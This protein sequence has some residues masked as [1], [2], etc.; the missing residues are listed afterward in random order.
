V[1]DD[2]EDEECDG[3]DASREFPLSLFDDELEDLED[4]LESPSDGGSSGVV[5]FA[6]RRFCCGSDSEPPLSSAAWSSP[7]V[8]SHS[9]ALGLLPRNLTPGIA[10]FESVVVHCG[11]LLVFVV[12]IGDVLDVAGERC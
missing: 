4:T 7:A 9:P 5:C 11:L 8:Q 3:D 6:G 2:E 12:V 10:F 1:D